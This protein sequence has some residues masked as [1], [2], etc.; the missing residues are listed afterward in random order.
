MPD[1]KGC[2]NTNVNMTVLRKLQELS[3]LTSYSHSGKYYT[4]PEIPKFDNDGLWSHKDIYFSQHDTLINTVS[5]F[6]NHACKGCSRNELEEILHVKVQEQLHRLFKVNKIYREKIGK[7]YVYFSPDKNTFRKQRL[8]RQEQLEGIIR[9]S[10]DEDVILVHELRA[11]IILFFSTLNE[12]QR[13]LY[14]GLESIKLG[15][16]GDKKI[17]EFLGVDAHTVSKG[18]KTLLDQDID[19]ESIRKKGGGRVSIEKKHQK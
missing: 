7:N 3:Y 12:Q 9:L 8:L 13:R 16:G 6:V 10:G 4:L 18:R 5:N 1:L 19:V 2:L 17:S 11:A 14:A 15:H